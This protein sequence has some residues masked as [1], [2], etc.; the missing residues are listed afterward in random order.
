M[1]FNDKTVP[2]LILCV[3]VSACGGGQSIDERTAGNESSIATVSTDDSNIMTVGTSVSNLVTASAAETTSSVTTAPQPEVGAAQPGDVEETQTLPV[4]FPT[5]VDNDWPVNADNNAPF[6]GLFYGQYES[7]F[8]TGNGKIALQSSRRFRADR[9]GFIDAVSYNN[10]VVRDENIS[11]RCKPEDPDSVWC[12]CQDAGLDRYS[13]GYTLSN[14]YSVGN[15]GSIIVEIHGNDEANGNIPD[16][17]ILGRTKIPFVPMDN[18]NDLSPTLELSDPVF[19]NAGEI[20]HLVFVNENPPSACALR[21]VSVAEASSCPRNQGAMGLNGTT[22]LRTEGLDGGL[23]P[24]RGTSGG[25]LTRSSLNSDWVEDPDTL[26]WYEIRYSDGIWRGDSYAA[27]QST[28]AGRQTIGNQKIARQVFTVNDATR[29]V[30]GMWLNYGYLTGSSPTTSEIV[31]TL[32]DGS[33]NTLATG[34]ITTSTECADITRSGLSSGNRSDT[35][36]RQWGYTDFNLV[37]PLI[38]GDTYSVEISSPNNSDLVLSTVFELNYSGWTFNSSNRWDDA[39]AE[40]STN[41]GNSWTNWEG[42]GKRT[43][44]LSLL[45]TISGMP[46]RLP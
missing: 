18:I 15:G 33:S 37:T 40:I 29:I 28:S 34:S 4:N 9:D 27:F 10:R 5:T 14:S 22:L 3:L 7:G 12:K 21:G 2:S 6:S 43:R 23:D 16:S 25:T 20:Y 19:L 26:S 30:D 41:N 1:K 46:K 42:A 13:C 32:K 44:D 36:C 11:G 31:I 39:Y 38:E 35:H 17:V 24:F 8:H 45:F